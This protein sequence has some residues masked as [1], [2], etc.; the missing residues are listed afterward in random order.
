M[1]IIVDKDVKSSSISGDVREIAGE[2]LTDMTIFDV[3]DGQGI[4]EGKKSLGLGLTLQDHSRT[5][6]EQEVSKCLDKVVASLEQKFG[7]TLRN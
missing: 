6:T 7:A 5:L 3:Y 2:Q 1:A 4:A